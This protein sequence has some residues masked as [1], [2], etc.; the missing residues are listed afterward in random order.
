MGPSPPRLSTPTRSE[1]LVVRA[2]AESGCL[3]QT[4]QTTGGTHVS[5]KSNR[6]CSACPRGDRGTGR[7]RCKGICGY[8]RCA[9]PASGRSRSR[10]PGRIRL[11]AGLLELER[12]PP[13]LGGG[14]MAARASWLPL[15][16]AQLGTTRRALALRARR[17][18]ALRRDPCDAVLRRIA[19]IIAVFW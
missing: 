10:S 18:E 14:I 19:Q 3:P 5:T 2:G 7:Q 1:A 15:D 16:A 8:R 11:G 12:S 9:T 17:L 4:Q 13:R 6:C